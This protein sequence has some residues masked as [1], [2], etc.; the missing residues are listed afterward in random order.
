MVQSYPASSGGG[1]GGVGVRASAVYASPLRVAVSAFAFAL[2]VI[3]ATCATSRAAQALRQRRFLNS[4]LYNSQL[5]NDRRQDKQ[6]DIDD[7]M[8]MM[9]M[10]E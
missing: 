1:V 4:V 3:P 5:E 8:M 9:M 2:A 10:N 7:A 6:L